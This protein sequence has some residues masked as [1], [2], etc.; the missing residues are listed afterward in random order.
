MSHYLK[1][2]EVLW[3]TT[4][5]AYDV[6]DKL[7]LGTY[8]VGANIKGFFL[9]PITDFDIKGKVYGKARHQAERILNTFNQRPHTTGVLLNGEKG[10]GKTMLAK[11]VS[12]LAKE[13]GISTLV[14]N[15]SFNGDSF[16]TF[17]QS[18]D[19]PCVILFDEF[20][21]VFDN[22]EQEAILTLLDGVFPT[23][24]LFM[25][26]SNDKSRIGNHMINRP[27]RIFYMLEFK[28]LDSSFITEYCQDNLK[29]KEY[30]E[31]ISK[32][33]LLFDSFNF[34]MLKALVEDM[35]RYNESPLEVMEMLNAKP[36]T[37]EYTRFK[38]TGLRN[39]VP[40]ASSELFP[41]EQRGN[42]VNRTEIELEVADVVKGVVAPNDPNNEDI[43]TTFSTIVIGQQ[44][45]KKIDVEHGTFTYVLEED[46]N[47]YV[48]VFTKES[49]KSGI[50]WTTASAF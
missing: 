2:G 43:N 9:Q 32:M 38:V 10:S 5:G 30:I 40:L 19:E 17:I 39:G 14:I 45:L 24:K 28:G 46:E 12:Q 8:T 42:P 36:F 50:S 26:T 6:Q 29:N 15:T 20:E 21:K 44:H 25:M 48:F 18:I 11:M 7:P 16:N 22:K 4:E 31:Q 3:P 47:H 41:N 23:K 13:Q 34:D 27:G 37:D 49:F 35:N 1:Q 33:T